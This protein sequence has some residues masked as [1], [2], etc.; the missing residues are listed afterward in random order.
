MLLNRV[1]WCF[2][3]MAACI[4]NPCAGDEPY[5]LRVLSYNIHHAEGVDGKLDLGRIAKV[6]Q[7]AQPDIVAL[8]EVD[9][10]VKRSGNVD[11]AA[12]LGRLTQM[13]S[14][15]GG[16]IELQGGKYG[17]AILTRFEIV[18]QQNDALPN[19]NAGEQR[20]ILKVMIK[21]PGRSE[22][23]KLY[24]THLDHR[25]EERERVLSA[26]RINGMI[27]ELAPSLLMGD[28]N[29]VSG[30]ATL[31]LLDR[32]WKRTH[33]GVLPTIPVE[34]PSRQIDFIAVRPAESWT[35]IETK[36]L[37]E[38]VASDHRPILAVIELK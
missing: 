15:F 2:G 1:I 25:R 34:N 9:Q 37:D 24:A 19:I 7:S 11:Q 10:N 23:L 26:E 6:I 29:D 14:A 27:E 3:V 30:S 28:L 17:N 12:E 21:L 22:G 16:N 8:Q 31:N 33:E 38:A 35:L 4:V 13:N 20:G 36:V 18:G 32:K 5:R